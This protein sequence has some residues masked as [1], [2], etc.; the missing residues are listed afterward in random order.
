VVGIGIV[1]H[2][3]FASWLTMAAI[4]HCYLVEGIIVAAIVSFLEML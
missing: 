3:D 2:H 1:R 4:W